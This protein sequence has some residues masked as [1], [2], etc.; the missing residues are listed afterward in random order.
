[1]LRWR[2]I[3]KLSK[4]TKMLVMLLTSINN[5]KNL[6]HDENQALEKSGLFTY[7]NKIYGSKQFGA[8]ECYSAVTNWKNGIESKN[9]KTFFPTNWSQEK[10]I[11]VVCQAAQNKIKDLTDPKAK[12]YKKYLCQTDDKLFID[13]IFNKKNTIISA[14]PSEQN[15][16]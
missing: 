8:E 15:F 13:I 11:Q 6:H 10:V 7:K 3:Q 5:S 9:L 12:H 4:S 2:L 1:M 14:Y 16:I